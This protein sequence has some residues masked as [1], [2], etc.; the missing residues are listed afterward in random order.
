MACQLKVLDFFP[1]VFV[2]TPSVNY[3][4]RGKTPSILGTRTTE[5]ASTELPSAMGAEV[6]YFY[7]AWVRR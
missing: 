3:D 5:V 7:D 6:T 4:D 2:L 1:L